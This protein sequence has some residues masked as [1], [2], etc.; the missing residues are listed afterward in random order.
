M[1]RES[2]NAGEELDLNIDGTAAA[3]AGASAP[4]AFGFLGIAP[5]LVAAFAARG[6]IYR[7]ARERSARLRLNMRN[8]LCRQ[9]LRRRSGQ[10]RWYGSHLHGRTPSGDP[11]AQP[12]LCRKRGEHSLNVLVVNRPY[13]NKRV[14]L[15][16]SFFNRNKEGCRQCGRVRKP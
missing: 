7:A 10:W 4:S 11:V 1:K 13:S 2:G 6:G 15:E 5:R 9:I 3:L 8:G 12:V 16:L 14:C